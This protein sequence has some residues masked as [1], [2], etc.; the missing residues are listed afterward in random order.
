MKE[1]DHCRRLRRGEP[2]AWDAILEWVAH[3]VRGDNRV[4]GD[5]AQM[6]ALQVLSSPIRLGKGNIEHV[7]RLFKAFKGL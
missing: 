2:E 5:P 3:P 6:P 1:E 7:E 4:P